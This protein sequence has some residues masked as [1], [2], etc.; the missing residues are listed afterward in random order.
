MLPLVSLVVSRCG[1][2]QAGSALNLDVGSLTSIDCLNKP[3]TI[4]FFNEFGVYV[5]TPVVAVLFLWL[6]YLNEAR[7][8]R[9]EMKYVVGTGRSRTFTILTAHICFQGTGAH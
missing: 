2:L 6:V 7:K 4:N 9:V 1:P 8:L 3:E 5:W